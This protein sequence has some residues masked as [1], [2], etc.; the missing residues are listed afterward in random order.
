MSSH[1]QLPSSAWK[2]SSRTT[3]LDI[4]VPFCSVCS[5]SRNEQYLYNRDVPRDMEMY[6]FLELQWQV[7]R[8]GTRGLNCGR[9][10]G[11]HSIPSRA[12]FD[13]F[14]PHFSS[15]RQHHHLIRRHRNTHRRQ[16][17]P[18]S[19]PFYAKLQTRPWANPDR[20]PAVQ[21][22]PTS[23]MGLRDPT[24]VPATS[25]LQTLSQD[26]IGHIVRFLAPHGMDTNI[27]PLVKSLNKGEPNPKAWMFSESQMWC[28]WLRRRWDLVR[29]SLVSTFFHNLIEPVLWRIL[30]LRT[31]QAVDKVADILTRKSYLGEYVRAIYLVEG[32]G[33]E[34]RNFLRL[35]WL[36]PNV[37]DILCIVHPMSGMTS[38]FSTETSPPPV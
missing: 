32:A 36:T 7:L 34:K 35:A 16:M 17:Y 6:I 26:L 15:T 4:K 22:E 10:D 18:L 38:Y 24:S 37:E 31:V 13:T 33:V 2:W 19:H 27:I 14:L 11:L 21:C 28:A 29:L 25:R 23:I 20:P 5:S 12:V 3:V 1:V 9:R 30:P 8:K